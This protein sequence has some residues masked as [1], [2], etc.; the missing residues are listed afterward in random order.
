MNPKNKISE[1]QFPSD[2][3]KKGR[4]MSEAY[5]NL[6]LI[7]N[8][9][10]IFIEKVAITNYGE[11]YHGKLGIGSKIN[12]KI[13]DRKK[14]ELTKQW[15]SL[16]G[17]S[18]LFYTDLIDLRTIISSNYELFDNYFPKESWIT[19]KLEELYDLRKK[20]AH[21]SYLDQHE[22]NT[23]DSTINSIYR[24]LKVDVKFEVKKELMINN[25]D[26]LK[27]SN[28]LFLEFRDTVEN[29][30]QELFALFSHPGIEPH[31]AKKISIQIKK[32]EEER[33]LEV[34]NF[35]LRESK[36][37]HYVGWHKLT[38]NLSEPAPESE[39]FLIFEDE[40]FFVSVRY[41]RNANLVRIRHE[42][43]KFDYS[44]PEKNPEVRVAFLKSFRER[45]DEIGI[46]L[47]E[48]R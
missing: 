23:L 33:F 40:F 41:K 5:F 12:K 28:S 7:E 8:F 30:I 43:K 24:Q 2:I 34:L 14:D 44:K 10:R 4:Q 22:Q 31:L 19:S 35:Y 26:I 13:K 21:N 16:R 32:I 17:D 48:E 25:K 6:Y 11:K 9:L 36:F 3:A 46:T 1:F 38:E 29:S 39:R 47:T 27:S 45:C 42:K 15:L 37:S 18:D 20:V